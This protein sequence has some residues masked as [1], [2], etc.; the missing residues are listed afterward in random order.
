[1]DRKLLTVIIPVYNIEDEISR[2]IG[3]VIAQTYKN[4]EILL[5][6]DGS[7]DESGEIC[8]AYARK[9]RRIRVVHKSNQGLVAARKTGVE[10][11]AG[12]MITFVD[13]DD[14]IE[15]DMYQVMM[16]YQLAEDADIVCSGLTLDS[17]GVLDYEIDLIEEGT[18]HGIEIKN[19]VIP[20]MMYDWYHK[21]RAISSS[22]ACK[23]FKAD[24]LRDR[25][26]NVDDRITLGEDAAIT[27]ACIVMASSITIIHNSWYHYCIRESSMCSKVGTDFMDRVKYFYADM[28]DFYVHHLLEN[29]SNM[30][31]QLQEYTREILYKNI[32]SFFGCNLIQRNY[33]FPY[34]CVPAGSR[35]V[36]Y[37]AG[38]IGQAYY[39]T[40]QLTSYVNIV[41][42]AD[43]NVSSAR[44][45]GY[46]IESPGAIS[47]YE[48]DFVV[49]AI[50]DEKTAL[51]VKSE[52]RNLGIAT[53]N[54]IWKKPVWI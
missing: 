39:R 22:V 17:M 32:N 47:G 43:K 52:L 51:Q 41:L 33:I 38:T 36:L 13:G 7:K 6:D 40:L 50:A 21:R 1:M 5:I 42:W 28:H 37:G 45:C 44:R 29:G 20:R 26:R 15:P 12:S 3:S 18:F 30:E 11:A 14:W 24:L 54:V 19:S 10:M 34:E 49:I 27:Y 25:L 53:D 9:D 2:C 4:I 8:D 48:Y 35:I 16:K 31:M 46:L 23:L